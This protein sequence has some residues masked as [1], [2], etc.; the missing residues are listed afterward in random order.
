MEAA[1]PAIAAYVVLVGPV[2]LLDPPPSCRA[3]SDPAVKGPGLG[4]FDLLAYRGL[5]TTTAASLLAS[6][7]PLLAAVVTFA[8]ARPS[9]PAAARA[10]LAAIVAIVLAPAVMPDAVAVPIVL[11]GLVASDPAGEV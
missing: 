7:A 2:A 11:L 6:V 9:I 3:S 5:E 10:G 8:L 4:V 1:S